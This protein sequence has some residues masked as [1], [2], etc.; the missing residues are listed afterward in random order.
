MVLGLAQACCPASLHAVQEHGSI[1]EI[2]LETGQGL[3]DALASVKAG[4]SPSEFYQQVGEPGPG[5][6]CAP[7]RL[8]A[9]FPRPASKLGGSLSFR[10][11]RSWRSSTCCPH[12]TPGGASPCGQ[13]RPAPGLELAEGRGG[14]GLHPPGRACGLCHACRVPV[15]G[16]EQHG[17]C[18][19][20]VVPGP[21]SSPPSF[22]FWSPALHPR[23]P[24]LSLGPPLS[25]PLPLHVAAW[26]CSR[27]G[28]AGTRS[29]RRPRR[30]CTRACFGTRS[31]KRCRARPSPWPPRFPGRCAT[32]TGCAARRGPAR[33]R[34]LRY[35]P[36]YCASWRP[37][38][39]SSSTSRS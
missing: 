2:V 18:R 12:L 37:R 39:P 1:T 9:V 7:A 28:M 30:R 29:A 23:S 19:C 4:I 17:T 21:N 38:S 31:G 33:R 14:W 15:A 24:S 16:H 13:P 27:A 22:L 20:V 35:P 8:H 36:G 34:V 25:N 6:A 3:H 10:R 5:S 11:G 26:S 32:S